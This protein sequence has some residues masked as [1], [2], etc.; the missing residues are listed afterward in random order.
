VLLRTL[1]ELGG[2]SGTRAGAAGAALV[3]HVDK[4]LVYQPVEMERGGRARQL[5]CSGGLVATDRIG[6]AD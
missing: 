3:G 5:E 4:L 1:V 2:P 6:L